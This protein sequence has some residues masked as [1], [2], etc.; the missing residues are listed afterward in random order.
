MGNKIKVA[1]RSTC[2][3]CCDV[4]MALHAASAAGPRDGSTPSKGTG[5]LVFR[6]GDVEKG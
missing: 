5:V 2:D 3:V 6:G 1:E 4:I